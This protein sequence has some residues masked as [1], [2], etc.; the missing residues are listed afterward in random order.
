MKVIEIKNHIQK[1]SE[2]NTSRDHNFIISNLV[3]LVLGRNVGRDEDS[4][5]REQFLQEKLHVPRPWIAEAK[6]VYAS[7]VGNYGDQAWYLIQVNM[8]YDNKPLCK[9]FV[10]FH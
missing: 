6:A 8:I 1:Y 7:T 2:L 9:N 5:E 3:F 4:S 10:R